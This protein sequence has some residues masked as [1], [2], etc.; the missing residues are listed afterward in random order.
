MLLKVK[1]F[2]LKLIW[3]SWTDA[4][5][6]WGI[7]LIFKYLKYFLT[8][9]FNTALLGLWISKQDTD[10][11][12]TRCCSGTLVSTELLPHPQCNNFTLPKI[13]VIV[14]H[15]L[16]LA[17]FFICCCIFFLHAAGN[18]NFPGGIIAKGSIKSSLSLI[19]YL[20]AQHVR[21]PR[22][23]QNNQS[24]NFAWRFLDWGLSSS[25][26]NSLWNTNYN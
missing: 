9:E 24:F 16:P 2:C 17:S 20:P 5:L 18:L 7:S 4:L 23:C 1:M 19:I 12:N 15:M 10:S 8:K 11:A 13:E 25:S 26:F 21:N 3:Q 6:E 14:Y 22:F